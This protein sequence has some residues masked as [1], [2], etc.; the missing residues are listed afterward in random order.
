MHSQTCIS[1]VCV[2]NMFCLQMFFPANQLIIIHGLLVFC[3]H[4]P[5]RYYLLLLMFCP[6]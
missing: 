6:Q 5:T 3:P 4:Y 2:N 1:F